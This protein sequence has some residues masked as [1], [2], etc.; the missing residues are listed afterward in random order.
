MSERKG[1]SRRD[2][3]KAAGLTTVGAGL[4]LTG[5]QPREVEKEVP[6]EV[7]RVVEGTPVIEVVTATPELRPGPDTVVVYSPSPYSVPDW[8]ADPVIRAMEEAT[9]TDI[10]INVFG[11]APYMDQLN[12]AIASG[13]TPDLICCVTRTDFGMF[14]QWADNGVIAAFEGDVAGAAPN[15]VALYEEYPVLNELRINGKIYNKPLGWGYGMAPNS[16]LIHVRKDLLD[17][18]GM[19]PPDTFEQWFEFVR[20][21][22]RDGSTGILFQSGVGVYYGPLMSAFAGAYGVPMRAWAKTDDG[23]GY[24]AVQPGMKDALLLFRKMV[25]EGLVDPASWEGAGKDQY[26]TGQ[27]CSLIYNGGGHIG[28]IQNAMDTAGQ[29]HK[30]WLIPAPDAGAGHRGYTAETQFGS[31]LFLGGMEHNNPVAAARLLNFLTSEEGYQLRAL[32][33]E[34]MH[35]ALERGEVVLFEEQREKDGWLPR[36]Q[37][38]TSIYFD[39]WFPQEW[40]D[41]ALLYGKDEAFR[42]FYADMWVNQKMYQ[43]P[44]YGYFVS[45][46]KWDEFQAMNQEIRERAWLD[47]L[48]AESEGEA[49]ALYDRF[50]EDWMAAGG[51]E[52]TPEVS[53]ALT[54]IYG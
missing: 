13:E 41:W 15:V 17:K 25:A 19:E 44:A 28:R 12:A 43:T 22:Q 52:A 21:A 4:T 50:V 33:I 23:Y 36:K 35:W 30:E 3:L 37:H 10:K 11:W 26:Q 14:R 6:V 54:E 46:P 16:G 5:C 40:Q 48:K 29:G 32:G 51:A 24:F 7:T 45:T 53:D 47:I 20:A 39:T 9:N 27:G 49:V 34:G 18:Y 2:F 8:D 38:L 42:Q 31:P 1:I